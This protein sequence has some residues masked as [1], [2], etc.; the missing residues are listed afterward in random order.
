MNVPMKDRPI[1]IF[2][3]GLGGLTAVKELEFLLPNESFVYFGD[4]GRIPYGTKSRET[5]N[6]YAAQDIRFLKSHHV[7]AILAACGTVSSVAGQMGDACGLPFFDVLS[8][9]AAAAVRTTKNGRIGV[10]GTP[11]TIASGAYRREILKQDPALY[12]YEQAC[13][14]FVPLVENGYISPHD[15]VVRLVVQRSISHMRKKEIDTLVL[16]CTHFPLLAAA[17]SSVIGQKVVLISSGKEAAAALSVFLQEQGLLKSP[18]IPTSREF[19]VS[20]TT[21]VFQSVAEIFLG[22]S[23]CGDTARV[24]IEAY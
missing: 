23:V 3:S 11:T 7:K 19:Y 1:G 16:G 22:H 20:D 14:M 18:D 13:P 21:K 9:T 6:K 2:D 17:I 12:V 4:T 8:A 10:I 5:I 24:D 15:E